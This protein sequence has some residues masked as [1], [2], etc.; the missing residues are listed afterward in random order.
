MRR[1]NTMNE[2][3]KDVMSMY[4]NDY[5]YQRNEWR[6]KG[7]AIPDLRGGKQAWFAL[8]IGIVKYIGEHQPCDSSEVPPLGIEDNRPLRIYIPFLRGIGLIQNQ[9]GM[10]SL[11][12]AGI[13]FMNNPQ[14]SVIADMIQNKYRL[15]GEILS[16]VNDNPLTVEEVDNLICGEYGLDWSNLSNTRRRMDWLEVLDLIQPLGNRKWD[17]T[18]QGEDI[19]QTWTL[20]SPEAIESMSMNSAEEVELSE[21]PEEIEALLQQLK[22]S[23]ELHRKRSTYNIWVPSPN[24][25]DNLRTIMQAASDRISRVDLFQFI[26]KEFNL[27]TSSTESMMPFLKVSGLLEEVGRNIFIST[28]AAKAWLET[29]NDLDFIRILHAHMRFVG[30][31]IKA[32]ENDIIRNDLYEEAKRFGINTEKARWIAGFLIE[33]GLIEEPQYLHLKSTGLGRLLVKELPLAEVVQEKDS[34]DNYKNEDPKIESKDDT[35]EETIKLLIQASTDPMAENKPSGVAFEEEIAELF[36]LM[37]FDA[38]RIGGSGDTDVVIHWND[39]EGKNHTAI[40][41]GK[42]KTSGQVSHSDISDVAID[43]HKEKNNAE[44]V[45]IVG[46]A[47][48]GDT[49]RNHAKKKG[50]ALITATELGEIARASQSIGLSLQDTALLFCVPNGLSQLSELISEKQR[51]LDIITVLIGKM[52]KEQDELGGLSPRDM[53]LLLRDN[54]ISPSLDELV[55]AFDRLSKTEIG[56]L[57]IVNN[58]SAPSNATYMLSNVK[59]AANRLHALAV[60]IEK[61]LLD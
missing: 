15:F 18:S 59:S 9:S 45:A 41:D 29:G 26:T 36:R 47:F 58:N 33:A 39:S 56:I 13:Q 22:E 48:S 20:V 10:I 23:P 24:R 1:E 49:I 11:T 51:E 38:R 16:L 52:H 46:H 43:T 14:K 40:I 57:Q 17:I 34:P 5:Q 7:W 31:M 3:R 2:R 35:L 32:C 60:A 30:E 19:L 27:K 50:F 55:V 44:Y 53:F 42:S 37:G 12:S 25:I 54:T 6:K 28:P 61:A 4:E 21:P 8:L